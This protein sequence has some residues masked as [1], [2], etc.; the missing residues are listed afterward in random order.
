VLSKEKRNKAK[1]DRD[2]ESKIKKA[3]K[4]LERRKVKVGKKRRVKLSFERAL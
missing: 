1:N 3:C 2:G 4:N